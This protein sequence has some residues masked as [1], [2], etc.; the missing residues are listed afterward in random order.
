[1]D[2]EDPNHGRDGFSFCFFSYKA[3]KCKKTNLRQTGKLVSTFLFP[4]YEIWWPLEVVD[5]GNVTAL[6]SFLQRYNRASHNVLI[7][8]NH[9]VAQ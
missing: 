7:I 9:I 4:H 6:T 1:M 3:H 8:N 5:T 2:G